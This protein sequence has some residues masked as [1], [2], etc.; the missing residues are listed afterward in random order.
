MKLKCKMRLRS[1]LVLKR[2]FFLFWM[3]LLDKDTAFKKKQY[4]RCNLMLKYNYQNREGANTMKGLLEKSG[5][6][7]TTLGKRCVGKSVVFGMYDI[8]LP[9]QMKKQESHDNKAELGDIRNLDENR[10]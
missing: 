4:D 8:E 6:V 3:R 10:Y 7:L 5:D 2:I 1:V 9:E